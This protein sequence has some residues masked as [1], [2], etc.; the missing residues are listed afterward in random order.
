M[1]L[2]LSIL[3]EKLPTYEKI[4]ITVAGLKKEWRGFKQLSNKLETPWLQYLCQRTML[5]VVLLGRT[6]FYAENISITQKISKVSAT[7]SPEMLTKKINRVFCRLQLIR[8]IRH[9]V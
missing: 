2:V 7:L 9:Y 5:M 3:K 8:W 6:A 1:N 4:Q